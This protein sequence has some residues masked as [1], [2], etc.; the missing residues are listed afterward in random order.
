MIAF[1]MIPVG[2]CFADSPEINVIV[3]GV[4]LE[5]DV[6]PTTIDSRTM[7]PV[8]KIFEALGAKVDWDEK[9]QTI[10]GTNADTIVILKIDSKDAIVNNEHKTLDVPATYMDGRTLVPTRFISESLGAKVEWIEDSNTVKITKTNNTIN[11]TDNSNV[12]ASNAQGVLKCEMQ[13]TN[14]YASSDQWYNT[15]V[16]Y[17]PVSHSIDKVYKNQYFLIPLLFGNYKRDVNNNVD[18]EYDLKILTPQGTVYLNQENIKAVQT[19]VDNLVVLRSAT[20]LQ[21]CFETNNPLGEYKVQAVVRD[22]IAK[23]SNNVESKV[24]LIDYKKGDYFK[25]MDEVSKF[26]SGYYLKPEPEKLIDAFVISCKEQSDNVAIQSFFAETLSKNM[27]L[28]PFISDELINEDEKT[29]QNMI[30][31]I[32]YITAYQKQYNGNKDMTMVLD[33]GKPDNAMKLDTW[34]GQF[35]ASGSSK[36]IENI[37]TCLEYGKYLDVLEKNNTGEYDTLS[38]EAKLGLLYKVGSWSIKSN[39]QQ[40]PLMKAYC[41]NALQSGVLSTTVSGELKSMLK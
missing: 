24:E 18:L 10:T 37:L 40:H 32:G 1:T 20:N 7:V 13:I 34:W 22:L 3:N 26:I 2:S 23:T 16:S 25:S 35:F 41:E 38:S 15:A 31:V 11:T 9:T 30:K 17:T 6:A 19:K 5:F 21:V 39:L 28:L 12:I 4:K 8:R 33:L 27:F 14:D 29:S 36:T